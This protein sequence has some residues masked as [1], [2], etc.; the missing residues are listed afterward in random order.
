[1]NEFVYLNKNR[2]FNNNLYNGSESLSYWNIPGLN[3]A[4]IHRTLDAN[5]G[6]PFKMIEPSHIW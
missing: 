5:Y 3:W 1:M 2:E 4:A 6:E